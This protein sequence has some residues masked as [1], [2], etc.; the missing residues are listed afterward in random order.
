MNRARTCVKC[1]GRMATITAEVFG[2]IFGCTREPKNL[3][4]LQG[5][6]VQ[7]YYCE[8]CGYVE[9]YKEKKE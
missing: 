2:N 9:F 8:D 5:E 4:A 6:K 1:G 3:D 7:S